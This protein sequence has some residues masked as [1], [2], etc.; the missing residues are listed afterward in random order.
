MPRLLPPVLSTLDLPPAELSAAR[1]DG[2]L[3]ALGDGYAPIDA[4]EDVS[5]RALSLCRSLPQR[6]VAERRTAAWIHGALTV[7]PQIHEFCVDVEARY[8]VVTG[9]G[10]ATREVVLGDGDVIT[11]GSL[12]V[13]TCRR[14][15]IDLLRMPAFDER[16]RARTIRSL[17]EI[18]NFSLD[19]IRTEL[20][21]RRHL[22]GKLTVIARLDRMLAQ[23]ADTRYT[24]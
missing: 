23:P 10:Y 6:F 1:L 5:C 20:T 8:R 2:E 16:T 14:T 22:P 3:F 13:T 24:S 4:A 17:A 11:I 7:P 12:Q 18:D 15:V 21:M 9:S 19:S